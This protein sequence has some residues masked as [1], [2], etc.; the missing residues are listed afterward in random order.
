MSE[1]VSTDEV[2]FATTYRSLWDDSV[3]ETEFADWLNSVKAEA[4]EEG[5]A[6]HYVLP[7]S[8]RNPYRVKEE[9]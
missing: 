8:K 2:R 5:W 9:A 1:T 3:T 4:F 7:G 6:D